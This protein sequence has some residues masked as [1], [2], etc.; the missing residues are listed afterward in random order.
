ML[1]SRI[2]MISTVIGLAAMPAVAQTDPMTGARPGHQPGVGPSYPLSTMASN[3]G[4]GDVRST[5]APT[6]P[7]PSVGPNASPRELLAAARAAL[8]S[9][10][11]GEA[12]EALERAQTR[13]LDR[14]TPLFQ[15]D[16]P[17]MNPA[18]TQIAGALHALGA[19][20]RGSALQGIDAAL[21]LA[22]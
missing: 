2:L 12:Q 22:E 3:T 18:V 17:S 20:D 19:G 7:E 13:L 21:P 10:R 4:A 1:T 16:Q 6:L 5:V 14:S 9:G 8:M 11:T 15:T